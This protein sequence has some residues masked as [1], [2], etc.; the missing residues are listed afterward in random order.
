[1]ESSSLEMEPPIGRRFFASIQA[2]PPSVQD[3]ILALI[4]TGTLLKDLANQSVPPDS[5]I[6]AADAFGYVL[7]AL[8][9]LPLAARRRFPIGVFVVVLVDAVVVTALFYRP[10]SFG[11]GLIVATYTV[12][13]WCRPEISLAAF[14]FAQAFAVYIKLRAQAAGLD[15]GW[16]NWPLDAC[17]M[18]AA[19][20]LGRSIL[21]R[22]HYSAAL[23]RSR[24][25][26]AERAVQDERTRIARELHD[27]VGHSISVMTLHVGAAGEMVDKQP[28]RAK[29]AL[30][31]AGDVGRAALAEM[32]QLL[33]LLRAEDTEPSSILRPSLANLNTLVDEFR[34]LGLIVT[35][36]IEGDAVALPTAVDQ[37]AFRIIQE[38]LTNT[39]K[40]AGPTAAEVNVTFTES[41]LALEIRDHGIAS[42][43]HRSPPG[44]ESQGIIGM[45]E[46]TTMLKGELEVG[47]CA[48]DGF[49]VAARLPLRVGD[50]K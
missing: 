12:A 41:D 4:L 42:G 49:R 40:H 46:R 39:L 48:G 26:L 24:E 22:Q 17:Y 30:A 45:R 20:F 36:T 3:S 15:V 28:G 47:H 9:T 38:A 2:I 21:S 35:A 7:V 6:R 33:G 19:W 16:F 13:R 5:P 50:R 31:S 34:G 29:E 32:D 14:A 23:E 11:F 27:A 8:L 25:S 1:M 44:H 37:S 18:G 10:T 43:P